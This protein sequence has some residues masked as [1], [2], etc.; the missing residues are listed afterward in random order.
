MR[1]RTVE[2]IL[3]RLERGESLRQIASIYNISNQKVWRLGAKNDVYSVRS[4]G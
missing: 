4:K 2:M 1:T 3:K